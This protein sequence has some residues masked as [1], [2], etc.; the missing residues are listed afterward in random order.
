MEKVCKMKRK[1]FTDIFN[2]SMDRENVLF[3]INCSED[4]P[5]YDEVIETYNQL[6]P[7]FMNHVRPMA[8]V[9]WESPCQSLEDIPPELDNK[10]GLMYMIQTAGLGP[11]EESR[12]RFAE[13]DYL[14][15]MLLDAMAD[16]YLF[17]MDQ[18]LFPL[19]KEICREEGFGIACRKEAPT[20]LPLDFHQ[21]IYDRCLKDLDG[22]F[23]LSSGFMFTPVKT[24]CN[25]LELTADKTAFEARHDCSR[26]PLKNC[27]VRL[28]Q[29]KG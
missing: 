14:A 6:L 1:I 27:P 2:V 17:S 18:F 23:K 11:E 15:G 21:Y 28:M 22:I 9:A 29:Q 26:C 25:V 3:K 16:V 13:G 24:S 10:T 4:S 20:D 5:V 12:R 8:V 19:L 7:W